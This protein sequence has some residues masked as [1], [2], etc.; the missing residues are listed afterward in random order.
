MPPTTQNGYDEG[1]LDNGPPVYR[2]QNGVR[3]P[4]A[5]IPPVN[6]R[7]RRVRYFT[8]RGRLLFPVDM[9]RYDRAWA[10]S[11]IGTPDDQSRDPRLVVCATT[12]SSRRVPTEDRW[13]S[14]GWEV[15]D[16]NIEKPSWVK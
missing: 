9:L 14:F 16:R 6:G 15:I 4:Y 12:S 5:P 11:G 10:V 8:V 2:D 1:P 13:V 3:D 7:K